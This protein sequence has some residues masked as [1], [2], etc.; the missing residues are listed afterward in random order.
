[1]RFLTGDEDDPDNL[2]DVEFGEGVYALLFHLNND[3]V[4]IPNLVLNGTFRYELKL[5]DE[6]V[7]RVPDDVNRPITANKEEVDRN[8]GD[9]VEFEALGTYHLPEG[10]S[11]SLLYRF[12]YWSKDDISG[13]L[14][15]NYEA[16]EA[17][18][19]RREHLGI[20]GLS[21][22]NV[23]LLYREKKFPLPFDFF[24][25]YRNRFAGKNFL[26]SEWIGVGLSVYF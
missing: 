24:V 14:G 12:G 10:L 20:V 5:P 15:F 9:V 3:Y 23:P 4:G 8:L 21:Y 6:E 16:L 17:E 1:M 26:K 18:T 11:F 25:K 2:N 19:R 22:S 13:S 7:L